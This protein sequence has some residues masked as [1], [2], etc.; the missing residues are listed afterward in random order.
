MRNPKR[1]SN[2]AHHPFPIIPEGLLVEL[3]KVF[4]VR[5]ITPLFNP[6]EIYYEAGI[7]KVLSFLKEVSD[8]QKET[9]HV[10]R[11]EDP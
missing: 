5:P 4:P 10:F 1:P 9:D 11:S 6:L 2:D 3:R 8:R 7:E